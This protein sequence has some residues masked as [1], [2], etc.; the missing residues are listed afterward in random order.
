MVKSHLGGY[1][2]D[3]SL[4]DFI[5]L[6]SCVDSVCRFCLQAQKYC[7]LYVFANNALTMTLRQL[8]PDVLCKNQHITSACVGCKRLP[9]QNYVRAM[10]PTWGTICIQFRQHNT[11]SMVI[12]VSKSKRAWEHI[13]WWRHSLVESDL[14]KQGRSSAW[15]LGNRHACI[16]LDALAVKSKLYISDLNIAGQNVHTIFLHKHIWR[17]DAFVY[18][19]DWL[20]HCGSLTF[21]P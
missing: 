21:Q 20:G 5:P 15:L 10:S 9:I 14:G 18:H 17:L 6:L 11:K 13:E 16:T 2:C 19:T 1:R 12:F 8:D 7:Q 3:C 4:C